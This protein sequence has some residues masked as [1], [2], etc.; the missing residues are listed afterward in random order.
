MATL[1]LPLLVILALQLCT[2]QHHPDPDKDRY[3][4]LRDSIPS[5]LNKRQMDLLRILRNADTFPYMP[6]LLEQNDLLENVTLSPECAKDYSKILLGILNNTEYAM[7][8]KYLWIILQSTIL[9][10]IRSINR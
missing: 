2:A 9:I 5:T 7:Q 4:Q 1:L 3:L 10:K 8:S 6:E